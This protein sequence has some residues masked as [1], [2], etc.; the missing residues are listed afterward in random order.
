MAAAFTLAAVTI[1]KNINEFL[2]VNST[3]MDY[4]ITRKKPR[5]TDEKMEVMDVRHKRSI[6]PAIVPTIGKYVSEIIHSIKN[7]K[8]NST[9][10]ARIK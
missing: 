9:K 8:N 4:N 10:Q 3:R 5:F 2:G 7:S 1:K 6:F